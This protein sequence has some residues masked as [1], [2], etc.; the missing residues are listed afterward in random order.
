MP[1]LT[2]EL[3]ALYLASDEVI[4]WQNPA[5]QQLAASLKAD[6]EIATVQACFAYVRDQIPHC[7][8][9]NREEMTYCASEVDA[10]GTGFCYAKSH[11][12]AALCRANGIPTGLMYQRLSVEDFPEKAPTDFCLHGLN[13]VWLTDYGWYRV[14]PR[15]NKAGV[16]AQ[17]EPPT[18]QLA[19]AIRFAGE[20]DFAGIYP[21]P[22][23]EVTQMLTQFD[24]TSALRPH[25]IDFAPSE[26]PDAPITL[27]SLVERR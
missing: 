13:A 25:F 23:T 5:I 10:I 17:C 7:S 6:T 15:G 18:E 4:D 19:F 3:R 16:N 14:D 22:V 26:L 8:D 24:T 1:S 12:L 20:K 2:P 9:A 21:T 11:L 27:E